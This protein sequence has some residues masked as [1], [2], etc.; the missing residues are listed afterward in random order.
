MATWSRFRLPLIVQCL[1]TLIPV[2]IYVVGDWL[3]VGMQW[4]FFQ[5]QQSYMGNSLILFTRE[6]DYIRYGWITG[7][8]ALAAEV[9]MAAS[10]LLLI[11]LII[12]IY[13]G[14][15]ESG[16]Q[17]K[18]GALST[19]GGGCLFLLS[20]IIQYGI[21]FHGPAG[22]AIPVGVP[23]MLVCGWWMYRMKFTDPR[24]DRSQDDDVSEDD[25]K[26]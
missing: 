12:F 14:L 16:A 1:L 23:A 5:Y 18:A 8:S 21:L 3:A 9:A 13:V 17:I 2:N 24:N 26:S 10:F 22:F 25:E 19:I 4:I 6:L 7:R 20:D 11:S 15:T